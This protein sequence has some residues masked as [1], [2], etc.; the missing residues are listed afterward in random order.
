MSLNSFVEGS[1]FFIF[2]FKTRIPFGMNFEWDITHCYDYGHSLD[3]WIFFSTPIVFFY[4]FPSP[5]FLCHLPFFVWS[6]LTL[7]I[8]LVLKGDL[9]L[10][11]S[12]HHNNFHLKCLGVAVL[13]FILFLIHHIGHF[14]C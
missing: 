1:F 5:L 14:F 11:G 13:V 6:S 9:L 10:G 4:G 2:Q 8:H 12:S 3:F 7:F